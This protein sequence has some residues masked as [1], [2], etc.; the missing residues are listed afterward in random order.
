MKEIMWD[1]Q[2]VEPVLKDMNSQYQENGVKEDS[3]DVSDVSFE[4]KIV[5]NKKKTKKLK[6]GRKDENNS[7]K[8]KKRRISKKKKVEKNGVKKK[9]RGRKSAKKIV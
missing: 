7:G 6:N 1:P 9:T 4:S 3:E 2:S 5:E 8:R